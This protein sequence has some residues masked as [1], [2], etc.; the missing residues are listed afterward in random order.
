MKPV[1]NQDSGAQDDRGDAPL[2]GIILLF[3]LVFAGAAVVAFTG[4]MAM[5]AIEDRAVGERNLQAMQQFGADI[6]SLQYAGE[7]E[8]VPLEF[9]S[10]DVRVEDGGS[11]HVTINSHDNCT[12]EQEMELFVHEEKGREIGY[13]GG[14]IFRSTDSGTEIVSNPDFNYERVELNGESLWVMDFPLV[15]IDETKSATGGGTSYARF[16]EEQ[17]AAEQRKMMD[18]LCL[19]PNDYSEINWVSNITIEI[20]GS[21][22]QDG[23][24]RYFEE[25]LP[26]ERNGTDVREENGVLIAKAPLGPEAVTLEPDNFPEPAEVFLPQYGSFVTAADELDLQ[27]VDRVDGYHS[28]EGP[29]DESAGKFGNIV[30]IDGDLDAQVGDFTSH[31]RVDGDIHLQNTELIG[32][33]YYTGSLTTGG[34]SDILGNKNDEWEP[35]EAQPKPI[36]EYVED[37]ISLIEEYNDNE[38]TTITDNTLEENQELTSGIYY[39]DSLAIADSDELQI[40]VSDGDVVI[41]VDGDVTVDGRIVVDDNGH[42]ENQVRWFIGGDE[43]RVNN[44]AEW[45][46]ERNDSA[47][48]NVVLCTSSTDTE[49]SQVSSFTGL[50]FSPGATI[51]VTTQSTVKGA[52]VGEI[53]GTNPT[54]NIHYDRAIG[55]NYQTGDS[56]VIESDNGSI[57]IGDGSVTSVTWEVTLVDS[58]FAATDTSGTSFDVDLPVEEV[59]GHGDDLEEL[60]YWQTASSVADDT[61]GIG[62]TGYY[63]E[64]TFEA[65]DHDTVELTVES[66]QQDLVL[67]LARPDGSVTIFD[68]SV[69]GDIE[70]EGYISQTGEYTIRISSDEAEDGFPYDITLKRT[71]V[72]N[73]NLFMQGGMETGILFQDEDGTVNSEWPWP[74]TDLAEHSTVEPAWDTDVAHPAAAA[75][76][77]KTI[78]FEGKSPDV[79]LSTQVNYRTT[80]CREYD[81]MGNLISDN[82]DSYAGTYRTHEEETYFE[83]GCSGEYDLP[84]TINVFDDQ[85]TDRIQILEDGDQVPDVG[86]VDTQKRL[87]DMLDGDNIDGHDR[88]VEEDGDY[89]LDL[90][91]ELERVIVFE[92]AENAFEECEEDEDVFHEC[93]I[94]T[95]DDLPTFNDMV[96]LVEAD[97]EFEEGI[98]EPGGGGNVPP[99]HPAF[100]DYGYTIQIDNG[101]IS[102]ETDD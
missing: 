91:N 97:P 19:P 64:V 85:G 1:R 35:I 93:G 43:I 78:T 80:V 22:Y 59:T 15:S 62:A 79:S 33:A 46:V 74:E 49:I 37:S 50:L 9:E 65:T 6:S 75:N 87:I 29:Y 28:S 53:R 102:I 51:D 99:E 25:E 17:T 5:D 82:Q 72:W 55:D 45:I 54:T 73:A 44:H 101:V 60:A 96:I 23:W 98:E 48:Q 2:I 18:N 76:Y 47:I 83:M 89:F 57:G 31:V 94:R 63:E 58:D 66:D 52:L 21:Q 40:D 30:V 27:N 81:G 69:D 42:G 100:D 86:P 11:I 67:E 84:E 4:I 14:G 61:D 77:P 24:K 41:A 70:L 56:D 13:Q 7:D 39:F 12:Y 10:G 3:G 92:L 36:T 90:E 26:T 32:N 68:E 71:H 20:E 38:H 95:E 16:E 34:N 8:R 88:L